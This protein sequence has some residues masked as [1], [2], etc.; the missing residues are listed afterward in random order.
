[1][2][3][4][5]EYSYINRGYALKPKLT[6]KGKIKLD[7][8]PY[9]KFLVLADDASDNM[10]PTVFIEFLGKTERQYVDMRYKDGTRFEEVDCYIAYTDTEIIGFEGY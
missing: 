8:L 5:E 10:T 7:V 2:M 4:A 9:D 1:M 6:N 3:L